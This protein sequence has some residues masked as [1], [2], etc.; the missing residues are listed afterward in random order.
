M[1][2]LGNADVRQVLDGE[3]EAVLAAVRGAYVEH[4]RGRTTVPESLFLRFPDTGN[5]IIALPSY[6]GGAKPVAGMKWIA[7]FPDNVAE[8]MERASAVV[9]LNS[10]AT[11]RPLCVMEGSVISARRTAAS[12]ALAS[13]TLPGATAV[14]AVTVVGCGV[15]NTEILR[16]LRSV[17][18]SLSAVTIVDLSAKRAAAFAH[19]C[20]SELGLSTSVA[21]D[22]DTA[23]AANHLVSIAT[24]ASTPYTDLTAARP[25]T[26]VLHVSL[27]DVTVEGVRTAVNVVD[28]RDHACRA[29]TSVHLTEQAVGHRDFIESTIGELLLKGEAHQRSTERVT[30]FSPFGLGALD[31]AVA[32]FV[33]GRARAHG[34]GTDLPDF[35]PEQTLSA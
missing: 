24:T 16:F 29:A 2:V 19:R 14:T 11:G 25:G 23:L 31:L 15:I 7:S 33:H 1:L 32:E 35:L 28:D 8:G 20:E 10:T 22:L 5:R 17:H 27:R 3:E 30:L 26:L 34:L 9:V 21:R 18:P 12:A 6:L 13:A 4:E